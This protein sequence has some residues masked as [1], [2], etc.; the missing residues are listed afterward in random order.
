MKHQ[1]SKITVA[2]T[3][4]ALQDAEARLERPEG[5]GGGRVYAQVKPKDIGERL[6]LF[7]HRRP[8]WGTR[9]LETKYVNELA[10]RI[11]RK[12]ELDPVLI[13][14][15]KTGMTRSGYE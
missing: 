11:T 5:N 14:K 2:D 7:Q 15:L 4:K 13:V 10:A 8:G 3:A 1:L 6:D 9:S 12:G